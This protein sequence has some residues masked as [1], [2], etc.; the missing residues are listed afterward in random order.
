MKKIVLLCIIFFTFGMA[1]IANA[2]LI[3]I[4]LTNPGAESGDLTGWTQSS[5]VTSVV[6]DSAR[7]FA[8]NSFFSNDTDNYYSGIRQWVDLTAYG[9]RINDVTLS[10]QVYLGDQATT[11]GRIGYDIETDTEYTYYASVDMNLT[12]FNQGSQ[13]ERMW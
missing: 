9:D 5:G 12:F 7:S 6:T 8:G 10:S 2:T 13:V 3:N 11:Y 4:D 1:G